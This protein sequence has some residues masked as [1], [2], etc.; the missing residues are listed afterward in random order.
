MYVVFRLCVT[1]IFKE[2]AVSTSMLILSVN[3]KSYFIHVT[4]NNLSLKKRKRSK[5][6]LW[7]NTNI[8]I[9]Y[10]KL[11][12]TEQIFNVLSSLRY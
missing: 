1:Y 7:K 10:N 12:V 8:N 4:L 5:G 6:K 3:G 2:E 9:F 11:T